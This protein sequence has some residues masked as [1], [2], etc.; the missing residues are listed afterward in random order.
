MLAAFMEVSKSIS[1]PFKHRCADISTN[2][3]AQ[4]EFDWNDS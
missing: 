4:P 1:V 3:M 2:I